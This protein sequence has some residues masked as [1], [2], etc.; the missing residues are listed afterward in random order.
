MTTPRVLTFS[1][2]E[3]EATGPGRPLAILFADGEQRANESGRPKAARTLDCNRVF[4]KAASGA[5]YHDGVPGLGGSIEETSAALRRIA[6]ELSPTHVATIG[7]AIGGYAAILFGCLLRADRILAFGAETQLMLPGTRSS[8]DLRASPP[9]K[10]IDL[11]PHLQDRK[12]A[13][14]WLAAG[15][16]DIVGLHGAARVTALPAVRALSIRGTGRITTRVLDADSDYATLFGAALDPTGSLPAIP[17]ASD[18]LDD[19]I[20]ISAAY[21]AHSLLLSKRVE[22]AEH[23]AGQAVARRPD[24]A[25]A[26]HLHGRALANLGRNEEA[27]AA[28]SQA[29]ALDP[30][31]AAYH[32]HLGMIL[33]Q[34]GRFADAAAAQRAA[35]DRGFRN[36]WAQ[37][38]LGVALYR[39]GDLAGAE[40]AHRRASERRPQSALFHHHLAIALA[41]LDRPAEAEL[42]ARQAIALDPD[43]SAFQRQL[44][45]ILKAQGRIEEADEALRRA[46]EID[47]AEDLPEPEAVPPPAAAKD[48][49]V[50]D[51]KP[52][53]ELPN[54][55]PPRV[56]ALLARMGNR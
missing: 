36:P 48:A 5:W 24:W 45:R 22:D 19:R 44:G 55:L 51:A 40:A 56:A 3:I 12:P 32:H 37:H 38:H 49:P 53:A 15:E 1:H 17:L 34:L 11:Q 10:F 33:A 52:P 21:E 42:S 30:S 41:E 20:A 13:S 54:D 2:L 14:V 9:R 43:N 6:D 39:A 50:S 16:A 35:L 25:L 4:V 27:E 7:A 23:Q 29:I 26:R 46:A 28:Q 8:K 47:P 31:Q 18:L